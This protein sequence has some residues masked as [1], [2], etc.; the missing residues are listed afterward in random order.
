[1]SKQSK[2]LQQREVGGKSFLSRKNTRDVVE[3][4]REDIQNLSLSATCACTGASKWTFVH[5]AHTCTQIH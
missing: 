4:H 5:I 1:M 2:G 3:V